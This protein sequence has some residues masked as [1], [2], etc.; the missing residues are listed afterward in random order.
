MPDSQVFPASFHEICRPVSKEDFSPVSEDDILYFRNEAPQSR[1]F[2]R[3][4][5]DDPGSNPGMIRLPGRDKTYVAHLHDALLLHDTMGIVSADNRIPPADGWSDYSMFQAAELYQSRPGPRAPFPPLWTEQTLYNELEYYVKKSSMLHAT[6]I[7]GFGDTVEWRNYLKTHTSE[8]PHL[9]LSLPHVIVSNTVQT[10]YFDFLMNI[11][12][13]L[14]VYDEFPQLRELP[15]ICPPLGETFEQAL[16]D[17]A[18]VPRDQLIILPPHTTARFTF[19]HLIFPSGLSDRLLSAER[20]AFIRAKIAGGEP[21]PSGAP[22]RRL[23]LSRSDRPYKTVANEAELQAALQ[24]YGF[25]TIVGSELS[26]REQARLFAE[27]EML[28][29]VGG[30]GFANLMYMQPGAMVLELTQTAPPALGRKR[31]VVM[32]LANQCQLH[33]MVLTSRTDIHALPRFALD[34]IPECPTAM[35]YDIARV[36]KAVEDG[37]AMLERQAQARAAGA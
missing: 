20:L 10:G 13:R 9:V 7:N 6:M 4:I 15:I 11:V 25:E 36:R 28:V 33:H 37:L 35:V 2:S 12:P 3:L 21:L 24:P 26:L 31:Q 1:P 29:G 17:F 16:A 30:G 22:R 14:W 19:K 27:A 8:V 23:Y 18:G 5:L 34:P 32:D